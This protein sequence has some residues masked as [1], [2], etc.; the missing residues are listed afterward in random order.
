MKRAA[1]LAIALAGCAGWSKRD[2]ALGATYLAVTTLDLMQTTKITAICNEENPII[3]ECGQRV[4]PQV[5]FFVTDFLGYIVMNEL[6]SRE[7]GWI[8]GL[9]DGIEMKTVYRNWTGYQPISPF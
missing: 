3:G 9:A 5:W 1:L 8:L 4:S 7:R 6:P 2:A